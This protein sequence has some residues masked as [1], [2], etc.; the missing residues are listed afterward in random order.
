ML[1]AVQ[2]LKPNGSPRTTQQQ[3]WAT[4]TTHADAITC[5]VWQLCQ[6]NLPHLE[7]CTCVQHGPS[8]TQHNTHRHIMTAPLS[9]WHAWH[10][11]N[12]C[13]TSHHHLAPMHGSYGITCY[14]IWQYAHVPDMGPL[15]H[16]MAH[17][18]TKW[19]P[20]SVCS[21]H[22]TCRPHAAHH[23]TTRPPCMAVTAPYVT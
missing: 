2:L 23:I 5:M 4:N 1:P 15:A 22:G 12:P 6:Q 14:L 7:T 9:L 11:Q 20:H 19:Q 10:I 3:L 13:S 8:S 17:T 16:R 21:M 18:D